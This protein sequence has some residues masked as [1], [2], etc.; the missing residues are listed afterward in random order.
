MTSLV[1]GIPTG[2]ISML[3]M[4]LEHPTLFASLV[5]QFDTVQ[6]SQSVSQSIM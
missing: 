5:S 2:N 3:I 1:C 6:T 4:L